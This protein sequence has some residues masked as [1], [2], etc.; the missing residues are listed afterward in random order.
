VK[1]L[2][3][4]CLGLA[5]PPCTFA[6]GTKAGMPAWLHVSL[7]S[8]ATGR[9]SLLPVTFAWKGYDEDNDT[10]IEL[11]GAETSYD[12]AGDYGK[13]FAQLVRIARVRARYCTRKI[14]FRLFNDLAGVSA[15]LKLYPLAMRAYYSSAHPTGQ[16]EP[17]WLTDSAFY[18]HTSPGSSTPVNIDT[19]LAA[20]NDGKTA[21]AYA[22][23][24]QVKQ[25]VPGR[26][27]AFVHINHVGHTFI[28]LIKYN[29]DHSFVCRS[30]GFY[31]RKKGF[32]SATPFHPSA[33]S[34]IKEDRAHEWDEM[35]G[36]FI[37]FRQF[38]NISETIQSYSQ[39]H[40]NLNH[41]NCTD[42]GL[43]MARL[44]GIEVRDA[45]GRWP[46]GRGN[47]PGSAGQSILEGKIG[48]LDETYPDPLFV[49]T[50]K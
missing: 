23:L 16:P 33:P 49:I 10:N 42:F 21:A 34:V 2:L 43:T 45:A 40:Y 18:R 4:I 36:K 9:D 11:T 5:L 6:A 41:S 38:S 50:G 39:K 13:A 22:I 31:P 15:R 30:F 24:V 28:T 44:G 29:A 26:R 20:F 32:L 12:S 17:D 37:S 7:L 3:Y 46:L 25:P 14:R 27:K 48:N 1:Q 35:A 19:V 8:G 47:N